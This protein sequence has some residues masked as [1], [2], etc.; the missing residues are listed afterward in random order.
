MN[1]AQFRA[2]SQSQ[3]KALKDIIG[4]AAPEA[5]RVLPVLL[6]LNGYNHLDRGCALDP[7]SGQGG[8]G[9]Q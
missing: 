2:G 1:P 4:D 8:K 5:D 7:E 6:E 9:K 3:G